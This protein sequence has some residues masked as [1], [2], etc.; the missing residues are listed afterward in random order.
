MSRAFILGIAHKT[1]RFCKGIGHTQYSCPSAREKI[2]AIKQQIDVCKSEPD[3][4]NV[5][6]RLNLLFKAATVPV[7]CMLMYDIW[8]SRIT[9]Y[10]QELIHHGIITIANQAKISKQ[11]RITI[12]LWHYVHSEHYKPRNKLNIVAKILIT[13]DDESEVDCPICVECKPAKEKLVTNCNHCIC[14][15]CMVDYLEHQVTTLNFPKPLCV[16]CR[17]VITSVTF[18]NTN[19]KNELSTKY[20]L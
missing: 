2:T 11:D 18:N 5:I 20:F 9:H 16:L 3:K 7:L 17:T 8:G 19:Y 13:I 1:C 10:L 14:K 6:L 4:D 15:T 12:L